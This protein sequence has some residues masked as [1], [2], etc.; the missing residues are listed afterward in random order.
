M[1]NNGRDEIDNLIDGALA[2][3]SGAEPGAGLEQRVLNRIRAEAPVSRKH[4][5]PR[6]ALVVPALASLL[7]VA[8]VPRIERAPAP[9]SAAVVRMPAIDRS[10]ARA[11]V[12]PAPVPR[13]ST[14]HRAKGLPKEEY[15]PA[16]VPITAEERTLLTF[17]QRH[18]KEAEQVFSDLEKRDDSPI[19]IRP[20]QIPP[21]QSDG[22]E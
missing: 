22:E 7:I 3:Y 5:W 20:I 13:R 2:G 11:A 15:F 12:A 19:E 6:W 1:T 10:P 9:K 16:P 14:K 4:G 8:I 18:P 21:L 17:V